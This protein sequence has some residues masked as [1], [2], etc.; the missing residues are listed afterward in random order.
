MAIL[1][2]LEQTQLWMA[3][4]TT[5]EG[6]VEIHNVLKVLLQGIPPASTTAQPAAGAGDASGARGGVLKRTRF[7]YDDDDST[8]A[9]SSSNLFGEGYEC[10]EATE[11]EWRIQ[12]QKESAET[13]SSWQQ[14]YEEERPPPTDVDVGD[15]PDG[16]AEAADEDATQMEGFGSGVG[17]AIRG[18]WRVTR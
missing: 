16:S 6:E 2:A 12:C 8:S 4:P 11:Q 17:P 5:S 3:R 9:G 10:D 13:F 18:V 7:S 14:E 15:E 1:A